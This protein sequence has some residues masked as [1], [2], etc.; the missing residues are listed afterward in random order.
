MSKP[1]TLMAANLNRATV[2]DPVNIKH[3]IGHNVAVT[4]ASMG[5]DL[6]DNKAYFS[7]IF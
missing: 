7:L 1:R 4:Y 3:K 2:V 6:K 5:S